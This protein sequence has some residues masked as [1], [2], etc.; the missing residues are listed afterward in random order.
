MSKPTRGDTQKGKRIARYLRGRPRVV[1]NFDWCEP[2][3]ELKAYSDSDWAGCVASQRSTSGGVMMIGTH[4]VKSYSR[5]QRTI[6]LSSAEAEL[7][8]L[9]AASAEALGLA[10]YA[11]DLG[12]I[13][14][15]MMFTDASAALGIAQ[16]R[17]LGKLRHVQTQALWIQQANHEKRLGFHKVPGAENPADALTKHLPAELLERH[18]KAMSTTFESGRATTAP[19]LNSFDM[20]P[21][22]GFLP[23]SSGK[24]EGEKST[25][26]SMVGTRM[27][28]WHGKTAARACSSSATGNRLQWGDDEEGEPDDYLSCAG[29]WSGRPATGA[30]RRRVRFDGI[31]RYHYIPAYSTIFG[32]HPNT[33]NFAA[34]GTMIVVK[35]DDCAHA[36]VRPQRSVSSDDSSLRDC[37]RQGGALERALSPTVGRDMLGRRQSS[38]EDRERSDER[39]RSRGDDVARSEVAR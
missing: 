7:H 14:K 12:M 39:E 4:L 9:V 2:I 38:E 25:T 33:F 6:A 17:G 16:R 28:R 31:V 10:A 18:M 35:N 32:R 13:L 24:T 27:K 1:L 30:E 22:G 11:F 36:L 8:A 34:D 5:Q 3:C 37:R 23:P 15:P 19:T 21:G 26:A 20:G 29:I